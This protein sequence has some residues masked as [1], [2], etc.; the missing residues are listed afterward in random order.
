MIPQYCCF[1]V[2]IILLFHIKLVLTVFHCFSIYK[3]NLLFDIVFVLGVFGSNG[4]V[5]KEA[6]SHGLCAFC[7][8][9]RGPGISFKNFFKFWNQ[10]PLTCLKM[11]LFSKYSRKLFLFNINFVISTTYGIQETCSQCIK[12]SSHT[13]QLQLHFGSV[14]H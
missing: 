1:N 11:N 3:F 4:N 14:I 5:I 9:S 13:S 7:M 2:Y 10:Q 8:V 12:V 6:E